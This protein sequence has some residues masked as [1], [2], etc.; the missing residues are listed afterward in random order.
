MC[1]PEPR[2]RRGISSLWGSLAAL[3]M[4]LAS[5][6][7]AGSTI[8]ATK[9]ALSTASPLSTSVGLSV[10][11]RGGNA[12]DAAVAAAFVLAVV[13]PQ[14]GNLGG[15]G[16]LVYY[17]AASKGVW[18]L[19]FREVAPGAAKRDM[20]A[21]G[22]GSRTGPLAAG[23]PGTVAGLAAA[24]ERFGS[25][26]WKDLIAPAIL[27]AR[28]G[29][30]AD[31]ELERE[32][33]EE[34]DERNI[35]QFPST[36]A[37]FFPDGKT[38]AAGSSLVQTDLAG[39]LERIANPGPSDFYQGET[40]A[41]LIDSVRGAGGIISAR[42]LREYKPLWRAPLKIAFRE[43]DV[44]TMAPPSAGGMVLAQSLNILSSYDLAGV[45]FQTPKAIH[46]M[47]EALRRAYIDRNR[48]IGDPAGTR[49]PFRDL[50]SKE[51]AAAW[52]KSIDPQRATPT[53][54]LADPG[55][56][57]VA[58]SDHTTHLSIVDGAGNIVAMTITLNENFGSGFVVPGCGF[59]LNNE[60]DDFTTAPGKPNRYGIVQGPAND[61]EP[62]KRMASSMTPTI[63]MKRGQPFL[64]LGSR[65]GPAIPT[66]ILQVLVNVIVYDKSLAEAVAARRYHHQ[67]APE[68]I[69]Y[70]QSTASRSVL[71]ALNAMGHGVK[72]REPIG[73]VHAL[74]F[75]SGSIVAVADPRRGG[76][77][78]G[79]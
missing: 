42:D 21:G 61:I 16:F 15:G 33:N 19:D 34:R 44:F 22:S 49:I 51:R 75:V 7:H 53:P 28:D 26:P 37:V 10:L 67:A 43:Y 31:A 38:L 45:G 32:L 29:F 64:V 24:H 2:S 60:M 4:T 62:G 41:R 73:D 57:T 30:T 68:E 18:T 69:F 17:D 39:T 58:E 5:S 56:A 72:A 40:A 48:Y 76:A 52:R 66:T 78:G 6:L 59:F 47:A 11:K 50:L 12:I 27:L 13:H 23:V 54:S 65:G 8:T 20:Y 1:H 9:A 71:E 46:L 14:A 35:D 70:E 77:A 3:A 25:Q 55:T 36:A 74:G 79:Y 63:V